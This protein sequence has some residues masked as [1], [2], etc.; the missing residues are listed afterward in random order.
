[1]M[2]VLMPG[3]VTFQ[4]PKVLFTRRYH[5]LVVAAGQLCFGV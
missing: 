4:P 2:T 3:D 1:M 5:S